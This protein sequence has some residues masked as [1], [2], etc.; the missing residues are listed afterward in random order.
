[1]VT[2]DMEA[3]YRIQ[4]R[5]E[6]MP[7]WAKNERLEYCDRYISRRVGREKAKIAGH[8]AR[9]QK[10]T[11]GQPVLAY[12]LHRLLKPEAAVHCKNQIPS[13]R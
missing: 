7:L 3:L 13:A 9:D 6:R 4:M 12:I 1:M 8:Q 11:A 2:G 5:A 10:A